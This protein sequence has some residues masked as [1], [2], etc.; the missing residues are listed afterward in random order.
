MPLSSDMQIADFLSPTDVTS[1]VAATD[2]QQLLQELARKVS[3]V[4]DILRISFSPSC[5]SHARFHQINRSACRF[6]SGNP[7]TDG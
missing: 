6:A 5:I 3:P 4:L 7:S 1:D 2:K